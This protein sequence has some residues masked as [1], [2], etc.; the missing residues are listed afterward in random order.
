MDNMRDNEDKM[1]RN[2]TLLILLWVCFAVAII[3]DSKNEIILKA[4]EVVGYEQ[5]FRHEAR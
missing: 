3:A 5:A 2:L 4:K 1:F